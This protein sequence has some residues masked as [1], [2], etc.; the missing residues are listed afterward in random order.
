[1]FFL[2]SYLRFVSLSL[3]ASGFLLMSG[4]L[5]VSALKSFFVKKNKLEITLIPSIYTT[6]KL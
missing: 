5:L 4:S 1:M 3:L 6:T 2:F